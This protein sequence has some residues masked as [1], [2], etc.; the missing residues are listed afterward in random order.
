MQDL[1]K[2]GMLKELK[3]GKKTK[4]LKKT[5]KELIQNLNINKQRNLMK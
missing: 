4:Q 3:I 5:E 2:N 1:W